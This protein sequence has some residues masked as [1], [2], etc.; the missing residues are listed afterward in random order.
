MTVVEVS[1]EGGD[2]K[3]IQQP[4]TG[5]GGSLLPSVLKP[6]LHSVLRP[7]SAPA[8]PSSLAWSP[9]T[10]DFGSCHVSS[11]WHVPSVPVTCPPEAVAPQGDELVPSFSGLVWPWKRHKLLVVKPFSLVMQQQPDRKQ[12]LP[13]ELEMGHW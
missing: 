5:V 12:Q 8:S 11:H 4:H 2:T 13:T 1:A 7:P 6:Y 3:T 10:G 9:K